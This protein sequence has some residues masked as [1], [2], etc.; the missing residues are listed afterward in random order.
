MKKGK[1]NSPLDGFEPSTFRLTAERANQLR[2]RGYDEGGRKIVK[3]ALMSLKSTLSVS[4]Q[5]SHLLLLSSYTH[6]SSV[7]HGLK[8]YSEQILEPSQVYEF[9]SILK[10]HVKNMILILLYTERMLCIHSALVISC[11]KLG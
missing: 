5:H 10:A 1:N 9:H 4:P 6:N 2:H 7:P 3:L 11:P 8:T